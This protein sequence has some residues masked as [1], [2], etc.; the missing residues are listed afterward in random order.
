[1]ATGYEQARSVVAALAGDLVA[2][3]DVQL[4]L[5][6][7]GVCSTDLAIDTEVSAG[8]ACCGGP[9]KVNASACCVLD[10]E[11]KAEGSAGCGCSTTPSIPKVREVPEVRQNPAST[12]RPAA[13]C[14]T[15]R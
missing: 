6:E 7:T 4:E 1:M 14:G 8:A 5:P 3:D 10:E 12:A 15:S 11:K 9:A 2:A 13:C